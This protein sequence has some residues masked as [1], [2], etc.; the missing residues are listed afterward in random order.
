MNNLTIVHTQGGKMNFLLQPKKFKSLM[1]DEGSRSIMSK[2]I[3]FFE[4]RGKTKLT[5]DFNKKVWYR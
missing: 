3:H 2:T 1:A 5:E 4:T